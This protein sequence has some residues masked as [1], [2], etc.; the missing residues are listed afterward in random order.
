MKKINK[1]KKRKVFVALSGGV[2]S[3]VAAA[4]LK[5]R[6]FDVTG[7]FIKVW[8][9][10]SSLNYYQ[11]SLPCQWKLDRLDAMRV[12]AKLE[13]SFFTFDFEKEY[14]KEI[15]DYMIS[16]YKE[17]KTPNPDVMCNKQI[18]FGVF[19][20]KA[21]EM[22]ADYIA[23]G[24]YV[25]RSPE[26]SN[27]KTQILDKFQN[28]NSKFQK[29]KLLQAKDKNKDQSYFLWTLT[30]EQL[31]YSFFPIGEYEKSK[32]RKIAEKFGLLTARKKDSQGLCFIGK[33]DMA[34]F[35]KNYIKEK[36][37]NVLDENGKTIGYH[38]G[39]VFFTIGQ[40]HGFI[41]TDKSAYDKPY[42]IVSKDISNNT[43]TVSHNTITAISLAG[44]DKTKIKIKALNWINGKMPNINKKYKARVRYR[45]LL[46][47]CKIIKNSILDD[48]EI[49]FD[50]SQNTIAIGQS[51]VVYDG[52]E[53]LGGGIIK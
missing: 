42:Y 44:E 46:Q 10:G 25:R 14:K 41:I 22:G 12:C 53:C 51:I 36:R 9:P 18:K 37:G 40:R 15:I 30:Q 31:K 28:T 4:L 11:D 6:G 52:E 35:L 16:E 7:V 49:E 19:L 33:L 23:T 13:I 3:S 1:N 43:I 45:Q 24:H 39:T 47:D 5:E 34:D 2:D 27:L 48:Y 8:H 17:G 26:I 29:I 21:I 50:K 32:V 20:K 38:N